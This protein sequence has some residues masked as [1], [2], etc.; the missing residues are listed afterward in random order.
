MTVTFFENIRKTMGWCPNSSSFENGKT[1]RFVEPALDKP[2][3]GRDFT[4]A[5][6]DWWTQYRN[7]RLLTSI[8]AT[9]FAVSL[10]FEGGINKIDI[11]LVGIFVGIFIGIFEWRRG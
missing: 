3:G 7:R 8:M 11:F 10:F 4:Y 9:L 2:G 1:I 6:S 5:A